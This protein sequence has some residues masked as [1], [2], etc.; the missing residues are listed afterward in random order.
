MSTVI[1]EQVATEMA[2]RAG[3]VAVADATLQEFTARMRGAVLGPG[4]DG[5]AAARQVGTG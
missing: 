4:A 5:Y 1:E 2:T 3:G